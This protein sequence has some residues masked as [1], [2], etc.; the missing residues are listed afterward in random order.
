M[1]VGSP[2]CG[3]AGVTT[4]TAAA[5][6]QT[7][8]SRRVV[9]RAVA[10]V[11][12]VVR[13][14]GVAR[15]EGGRPRRRRG[16]RRRCLGFRRGPPRRGPRGRGGASRCLCV[17]LRVGVDGGVAPW[18]A[19][20]FCPTS[21]SL[22]VVVVAPTPA[23][24]LGVR[25][26]R[27]RRRAARSGRRTVKKGTPQKTH[28]GPRRRAAVVAGREGGAAAADARASRLP[29][30]AAARTAPAARAGWRAGLTALRAGGVAARAARARAPG[31]QPPSRSSQ[32]SS[33]ALDSFRAREDPRRRLDGRRLR[34]S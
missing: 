9:V 19:P 26:H 28:R 14:P 32:S 33:S 2:A 24:V 30:T 7:F 15:V 22:A 23:E 13:V 3:G 5:A 8:L 10:L 16:R 12:V 20:C 27:R 31:P 6:R 17:L 4:A 25:C 21:L 11:E 18:T 34:A 1:V 29:P